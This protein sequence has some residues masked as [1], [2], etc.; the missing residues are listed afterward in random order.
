MAVSGTG[1]TARG[2]RALSGPEPGAGFD[3]PGDVDDGALCDGL[4]SARPRDLGR[5]ARATDRVSRL[6]GDVPGQAAGLSADADDRPC[7]RLD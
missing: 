5:G 2:A 7:T 6:V 4:G 3:E 1:M